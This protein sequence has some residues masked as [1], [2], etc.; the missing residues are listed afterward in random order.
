VVRWRHDDFL[1]GLVS[2]D[3]VIDL[4]VN[5]DRTWHWKD[6][7]DFTRAI[8]DGILDPIIRGEI[9]QETH[10]VLEELDAGVGPFADSWTAFRPDRSCPTPQLPTAY[11][12]NGDQWTLPAGQ[13]IDG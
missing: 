3:L 5:P 12:W 8:T 6:R 7:A 4:W 9:D 13:R 1:A 2:E 10:R 11:S